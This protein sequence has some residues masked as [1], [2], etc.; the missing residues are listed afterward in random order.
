MSVGVIAYCLLLDKTVGF[1]YV[2]FAALPDGQTCVGFQ[3]TEASRIRSVFT[4]SVKT[5]HLT[6]PNDV[7]NGYERTIS[8]ETGE[9]ILSSPAPAEEI[10]D[11]GHMCLA[12][13]GVLGVVGIWGGKSL[14]IDRSPV[15]R[16][17][18][19][20]NIRSE[21]ICLSSEKGALRRGF[22][23]VIVDTAFAV[24]AGADLEDTASCCA[25][26]ISCSQDKMKVVRMTGTDGKEYGIAVNFSHQ[27][28]ETEILG[29]KV[30]VTPCSGKIIY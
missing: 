10:V 23:E 3:Y 28:E 6:I 1:C 17:G 29:R 15:P 25:E 12:V 7:Y 18:E 27:E 5:L 26:Q 4:R 19:Y 13:D 2:A 16:G 8:T 11:T 14:V 21:E 9:M 30:S 20:E 24:I 22:G